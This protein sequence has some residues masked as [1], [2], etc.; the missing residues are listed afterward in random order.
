MLI[1]KID[2][3]NFGKFSRQRIDFSPDF[4]L[5]FGKNEDG[6]STLMAFI[7]MMFYG[8]SSKNVADISK[9]SRK[10]YSPWNG[11][12][13]SGAIEVET[14]DGNF[15]IHKEFKK[16]SA[17]D[18]VTVLNL[19]T[20]EK[21]PQLADS[22][23]GETF[24]DMELGEF[25]RSVF[26][27]NFGGF[28]SDA[29][30]DSLAMRISNLSVT[31][32]ENFSQTAVIQRISSAKEELISKSRKKGLL[33][34]AKARLEKLEAQLEAFYTE[35][36]AQFSLMTDISALKNEILDIENSLENIALAEKR[37]YAEKELSILV[38]LLE[39]LEKKQE[40]LD[41]LEKFF[42][43]LNV[44]QSFITQ[45]T[46]LKKQIDE[47][48]SLSSQNAY[49]SIPDSVYIHLHD[50]EQKSEVSDRDNVFL[51]NNIIP[52]KKNFEKVLS[53]CKKK[54]TLA[55]FS[56]LALSAVLGIG[57]IFVFKFYIALGLCFVGIVAFSAIFP[58]NVTNLFKNNIS[59]RLAK[60]EF[61]NSLLLLSFYSEDLKNISVD[62]IK[63]RIETQ[64]STLEAEIYGILEENKCCTVE[65]LKS[66]TVSNQNSYLASV[67]GETNKLKQTFALNVSKFKEVTDFNE[68][69]SFFDGICKLSENLQSLSAEIK[70]LAVSAGTTDI[71]LDAVKKQFESINE[72]LGGSPHYNV[73]QT[74]ADKLK[75]ILQE[76]RNLLGE[77]Q[78]KVVPPSQDEHKLLAL[79]EETHAEISRFTER[80][81]ALSLVDNAL[82]M[83]IS[84]MNKGLGSHLSKK[85]GEYLGKLSGGKYSDVLVSRDL[86]VEARSNISDGYHEWKF[87]SSGAIDR[88]YLALRLAATDIC[89]EKNN[90]LPLF[91]D[92]ILAQ[93]DDESCLDAL[94]FLKY[95]LE[96]SGSVSQVFFFTC[97]K[98]IQKMV[99]EIFDNPNQITL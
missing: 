57:S 54:R 46:E 44:L 87:L 20:G 96:N 16:T 43:D 52:A 71:N 70:T 81:D 45:G 49:N 12:P 89:A 64:K 67:L 94:R 90:P 55:A 62:E 40:T 95:Y 1:K 17:S 74:D 76:K 35:S 30:G 26:I 19:D 51:A 92:D 91:M 47:S 28:T 21:Q 97:H 59:V 63:A 50:L 86:N 7:K 83:A 39:K 68:A 3:E 66:K 56:V 80:Y 36:K 5:I 33:V 23:I 14:S 65:E 29:A 32:D 75:S 37:K 9:N 60:Q 85:T 18:K 34:D 82:E 27:E 42:P 58:K 2:I 6:K 77:L 53:L 72:F 61:E 38:A 41:S 48:Y 84:E 93:Y 78:S 79:I 4:N 99:V 10:K 24:F 13:M 8:N 31:G 69:R 15:R 11:S 25:E 73:D 88:T 22:E 98:H